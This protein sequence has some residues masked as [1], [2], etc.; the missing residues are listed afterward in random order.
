MTDPL[1]IL[2]IC[3]GNRARSQMAQGWLRRRGGPR[4][5]VESCPPLPGAIPT[6]PISS[7]AE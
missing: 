7:A 1:R 3:S 6:A 4:V 5:P 2:V